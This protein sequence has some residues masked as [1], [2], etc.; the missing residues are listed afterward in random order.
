MHASEISPVSLRDV[1][2]IIF[3]HKYKILLFFFAVVITVSVG[4]LLARPTYEASAQILIKLGR[5]SVFVPASGDM[6]PVVNYNREERINSEIEI[7][8]SRSLAEK[9]V[10]ALGPTVIYESLKN[11]K[12]GLIGRIKALIIP[13]EEKKLT[14]DER[15]ELNLNIATSILQ[16][17][18]EVEGIQKSNI[19]QV[20]FQHNDPR[21]VAMVVNKLAETYLEHHLQ[22]HKTP[23][24]HRFFQEQ[25]ELLKSQLEQAEEQLKAIKKQH[26]I[27]S[28]EQERTLMLNQVSALR[29]DLNKTS[30]QEVETERRIRQLRRQLDETPRTIAQGEV[31]DRNQQLI[32]TL[33]ARLV[34]LEL[35]E[36]ELL[37][38]YTDQSRLVQRVREEIRIVRAKLAE[39]EKKI[40]G[41]KSS[42]VNPTYQSLQQE[43]YRNEAELNALKAKGQTQ[44][45]QL[46]DYQAKLEELNQIEVKINQLQ[47]QVD[48]DRQ[49]YRLYLT[50]FEESRISDAMDTEKIASV[51]LLEPA[52]QPMNPVSPKMMLNLLLALFLG[53]FGGLGLAF[54]VDY[55]DDSLETV[56]AVEEHLQMPVLLS[57]AEEK[58]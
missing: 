26:N 46:A 6:R 50:K 49:N 32:G 33:E 57:V 47:Q 14:P 7:L 58:R 56:E 22:V 29:A 17:N 2:L 16:K 43:L 27:T 23:Q 48:V 28:L 40:Y 36:K 19:V 55:L 1:F 42:G 12:P 11:Q 18:L 35:E 8:K 5:E 4:T 37:T 25:S 21:M 52:R 20:S 54:F 30:S 41:R 15:K 44:K 34:E 53:A 9:V 45:S 24:S 13:R 31:V 3:K 39:Q 38:K 51:S 10:L